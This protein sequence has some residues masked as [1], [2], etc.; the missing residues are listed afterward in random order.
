[1]YAVGNIGWGDEAEA[2][3]LAKYMQSPLIYLFSTVFWPK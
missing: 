2:C 1:M 3:G